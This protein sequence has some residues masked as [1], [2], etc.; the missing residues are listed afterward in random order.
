MLFLDLRRNIVIITVDMAHRVEMAN[1]DDF[2]TNVHLGSCLRF[3]L[4][5][6]RK[7]C[8]MYVCSISEVA[9]HRR[10]LTRQSS[11]NRCL[12]Q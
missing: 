1:I 8:L 11:K 5:K 2:I 9:D 6:H 4:V 12:M 10:A 3:V 7:A